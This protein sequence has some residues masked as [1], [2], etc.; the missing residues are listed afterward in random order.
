MFGIQLEQTDIAY[1]DYWRC[2]ITREQDKTVFQRF[3]DAECENLE[4]ISAALDIL[5]H[6]GNRFEIHVITGR[7]PKTKMLTQ[8]WLTRNNVCYDKLDFMELKNESNVDFA[9]FIDDNRE[10]A[11]AIADNGINSILLNYPWNQPDP[12]DP[13]NV[14]RAQSWPDIKR[15]VERNIP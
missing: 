7:P 6:F 9:A 3:H 15:Y 5:G 8:R 1:F 2:G 12:T 13:P 11:Y 10:T 4:P 14:F